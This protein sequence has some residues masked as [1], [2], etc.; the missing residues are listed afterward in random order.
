[1]RQVLS[2]APGID[3]LAAL[4][5][6]PGYL[7]LQAAR[8][9]QTAGVQGLTPYQIQSAYG[10]YTGTQA[11]FGNQYSATGTLLKAGQFN[12]NIKLS[13]GKIGDGSGQTIA[14]IDSGN[15]PTIVNDLK[16]FSLQFGL[17]LMNVAG[18]PT[19]KVVNQNGSSNPTTLPP[20][21]PDSSVETSL[22][23]E[24]VHSIAPK[25]NILLVE[26][27]DPFA[28]NSG[29]AVD[30]ISMLDGNLYARTAPGVSV[31]SNSW[32]GGEGLGENTVDFVFSTPGGHTGETFV[33]SAGDSGGPASYPSASPN[34]LSVGGT[35]LKL[36]ATNAY[37]NETVWNDAA[38]NDGAGG[39]GQSGGLILNPDGTL[40]LFPLEPVPNF[41]KGLGLTSRG[42][43]D[44]SWDADPQTGFAVYDS[45]AFGAATPWD[46]I[47]GTSAGAPQWSALLAIADQ[48]RTLVG[49]NSLSNA[50][51]IMYSL[52]KSD[53]HDITVGNN[54][55][56]GDGLGL[57]GNAAGP[58]YDLASG[59]GTPIAN[60]VI[61][62][63]ISSSGTSFVPATGGAGGLPKSGFFLTH[64][65]ASIDTVGGAFADATPDAPT[66]A[67]LVG[68]LTYNPSTANPPLNISASDN[69]VT[70]QD[71]AATAE[72]TLFSDQIQLSV[73]S[74]HGRRTNHLAGSTDSIDSYFAQHD[75]SDLLNVA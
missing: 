54:D 67:N 10:F 2:A 7:Q 50:Q 59:I 25:A 37:S 64:A 4:F 12:D 30:V 9:H 61:R 22:D 75:D 66:I 58:G 23:V 72:P 13:G 47:G 28:P 44:V 6:E 11:N 16:A 53:F 41:Q 18:G 20:N 32:G 21:D 27:D 73:S 17:P 1:M 74:R 52:P 48:G 45:Y 70:M 5:T 38:I 71:S 49:K 69:S 55:Y 33:F 51:A 62:D 40:S 57:T 46:T 8:T 31:I 14:I 42:T 39:G 36:S 56:L 3:S 60:L 35:T 34:V 24:W 19:F 15:S 29:G 26:V 68:S 65:K 63:L 43:P